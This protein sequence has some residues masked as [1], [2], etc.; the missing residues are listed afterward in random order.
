MP[1][2][3]DAAGP[4]GADAGPQIGLVAHRVGDADELRAE[5]AQKR[6]DPFDHVQVGAAR[7]GVEGD[8]AR[9]DVADGGK[10]CHGPGS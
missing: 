6:L 5:R 10:G 8:K 2:K 9:E 3:D 4:V 1:G 7:C